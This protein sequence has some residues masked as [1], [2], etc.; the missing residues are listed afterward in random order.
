MIPHLSAARLEVYRLFCP[1]CS[2]EDVVRLYTWHC[3]LASAWHATL[4]YVEIIL[5][6]AASDA[7]GEWN[8]ERHSSDGPAYSSEWLFRPARPLAGLIGGDKGMRAMAEKHARVAAVKRVPDH[9][10]RGADLTHNDVLT[11][12]TFGNWVTL[13]P[14][15]GTKRTGKRT[16]GRGS[17][18]F[19]ARE[20]L[21]LRG[22]A[23][24]FPNLDEGFPRDQ[25]V[26]GKNNQVV[27]QGRRL[28]DAADHLLRLRNRIAHHEQV[29]YANHE[30]RYADA[31][32][33]TCAVSA[34]VAHALAEISQVR[35]ILNRQP[36]FARRPSAP[37]KTPVP[38]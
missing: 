5:R 37:L 25:R 27:D 13:L 34:D 21:G 29:L 36:A 30:A 6:N 22:I 15:T 14:T 1:G 8:I 28:A 31:L 16:T 17:T 10:R 24:G 9:P 23:R 20:N 4:G 33:I 26:Q 12:T 7:L 18:G 19:S 35:T 3:E 11:Q 32:A 2:D 38:A